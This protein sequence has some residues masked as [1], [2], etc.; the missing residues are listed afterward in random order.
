MFGFRARAL[1]AGS[2]Q[3]V[4]VQARRY[5]LGSFL[6]WNWATMVVSLIVL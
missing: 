1:F 5:V 6:S 4:V 2:V 3:G